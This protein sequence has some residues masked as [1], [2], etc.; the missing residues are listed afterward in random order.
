LPKY[1]FDSKCLFK[2]QP[3]FQLVNFSQPSDSSH[4]KTSKRKSTFIF[5]L[6]LSQVPRRWIYL[7]R[8][9]IWRHEVPIWLE[10]R[11]FDDELC[12]AF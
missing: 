6:S 8:L 10:R 7:T 3:C 2:N 11:Q 1:K 4:S 9:N 5:K 12:S